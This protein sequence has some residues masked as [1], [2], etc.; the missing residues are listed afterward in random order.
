MLHYV[1]KTEY[2]PVVQKLSIL[3]FLLYLYNKRKQ[4]LVDE[5]FAIFF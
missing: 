4:F 5:S 1:C 2:L 3:D